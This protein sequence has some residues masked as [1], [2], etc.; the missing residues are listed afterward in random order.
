MATCALLLSV[1]KAR[2][3]EN[4]TEGPVWGCTAYQTAPGQ[5]Q[6]YFK[7]LRT[8]AL[9]I[10]TEEKK[11][12]LILDIKFFVKAPHDANDWDV[13]VCILH[14]SYG[15]A[16]DYN[17]GDDDKMKAI[18][19]KQWKTPDEQKQQEMTKPRLEM[20]RFLGT[21]YTREVTLRPMP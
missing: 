17:K 12:G 8:N 15:Q 21:T 2:A 18:L 9:P 1:G 14:S 4:W 7:W 10:Y 11:Q 6:N 3:Q 16:L 20:R 13:L 5:F 19:A